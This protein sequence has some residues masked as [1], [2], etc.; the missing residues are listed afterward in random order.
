MK[1]IVQ[2]ETAT[3]PDG[4]YQDQ[5]TSIWNSVRSL[6]E[7]LSLRSIDKQWRA[8]FSF[9]E[10]TPVLI[11]Q[12]PTDLLCNVLPSTLNLSIFFVQKKLS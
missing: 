11:T 9:S 12:A 1:R 10:Y 2:A 3:M 8:R 5:L 4:V 6:E 7:N